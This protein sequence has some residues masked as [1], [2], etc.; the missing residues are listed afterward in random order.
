HLSISKINNLWNGSVVI[1]LPPFLKI[2][3]DSKRD[4]FER[5]YVDLVITE[6]EGGL[7]YVA[8]RLDWNIPPTDRF[9]QGC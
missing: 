9:I 8:S 1:P 6:I 7:E 4:T 3:S 2:V 5:Q